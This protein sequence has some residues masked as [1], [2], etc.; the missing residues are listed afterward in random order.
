MKPMLKGGLVAVG[1]AAAILMASAA[2]AIR[3]ATRLVNI[4]ATFWILSS[5]NRRHL[6]ACILNT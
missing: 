3:V 2:V 4:G 6:R 5:R 1:Y